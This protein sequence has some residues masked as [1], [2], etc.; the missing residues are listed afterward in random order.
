MKNFLQHLLES[1]K[2]SKLK[3]G[4]WSQAVAD[5]TMTDTEQESDMAAREKWRSKLRPTGKRKKGTPKK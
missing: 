5:R 4:R 2:K 1:S 3:V